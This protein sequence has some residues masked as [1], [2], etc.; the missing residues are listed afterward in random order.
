MHLVLGTTICRK[1]APLRAFGEARPSHNCIRD[2]A[3]RQVSDEH[4]LSVS[5]AVNSD[6]SSSSEVLYC[7]RCAAVFT[8]KHGKGNLGRHR[9]QKHHGENPK[10]YLCGC[11]RRFQRMDSRLKHYRKH[12]PHLAPDNKVTRKPRGQSNGIKI[13]TA[14]MNLE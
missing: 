10:E 7:D 11:G 12:H 2:D 14:A 13:E 4:R 3:N 1:I 5:S 9:R 8:G 6:T